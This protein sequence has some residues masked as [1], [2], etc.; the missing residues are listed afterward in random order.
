MHAYLKDFQFGVETQGGC[1]AILHFVNRL[2]ECKG[3][4]VG[5]SMLLVYFQNAFNL[6]DK[7]VMLSEIRT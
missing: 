3:D 5:Y 2:I 6:V 4:I 1:E 7:G